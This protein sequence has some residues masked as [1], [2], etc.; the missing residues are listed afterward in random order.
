MNGDLIGLHFLVKLTPT[1][2]NLLHIPA[3]IVLAILLLQIFQNYQIDGR[4]RNWLVLLCAGLIGV[5]SEIVQIVIPGRY[6][7]L[8]DIGLNLIGTLA[9][10][11][12]FHYLERVKPGLMRRM[13]CE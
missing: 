12:I 13:V 4:R 1:I 9:G 8:L 7:G 11:L 10:I 6:P 3:Y 5:F 2:Q